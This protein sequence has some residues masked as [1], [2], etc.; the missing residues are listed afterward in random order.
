MDRALYL[1]GFSTTEL[2]TTSAMGW[3]AMAGVSHEDIDGVRCWIKELDRSEFEGAEAEKNLA[4]I[5]WLTPRVLAH[6]SAVSA[7][8][9]QG[10]FFPARFGSL[11]SGKE[12]LR[13]L[14][15]TAKPTILSFLDRVG[16]RREWGVKVF[17]NRVLAEESYASVSNTIEVPVADSG[18]NYLR[19]R[20][21]SKLREQAIKIWIGEQVEKLYGYLESVADRMVER[22]IGNVPDTF[23]QREWIGNYALLMK[24]SDALALALELS[25]GG[26]GKIFADKS[27]NNGFLSFEM[28]GPWPAYSFIPS[29]QSATCGAV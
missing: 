7:L 10:R 15:D 22:N 4:D 8:N 17:L 28:T 12:P 3:L 18:T 23:A 26:I 9:K 29:L 20:H 16:E 6:D 5:N 24:E 14:V 21:Q 27:N 1:I 13:A 25:S 19:A 2:E 11:F